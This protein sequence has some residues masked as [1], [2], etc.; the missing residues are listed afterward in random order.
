MFC[1]WKVGSG[2]WGGGETSAFITPV[3]QTENQLDIK[4]G[5]MQLWGQS[6]R[7]HVRV[8]GGRPES[9]NFNFNL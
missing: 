2:G 8:W 7:W 9:D 1:D 5:W 3:K 4:L 6:V